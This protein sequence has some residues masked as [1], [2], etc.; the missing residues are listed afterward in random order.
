M[1]LDVLPVPTPPVSGS[2]TAGAAETVAL[3]KLFAIPQHR[4]DDTS[5]VYWPDSPDGSGRE[6]DDIPCCERPDID[7]FLDRMLELTGETRRRLGTPPGRHVPSR[8]KSDDDADPP[9]RIDLVLYT[10]AASAKS[11][12]ALRAVREVL[13]QYVSSQVK[14]STCDLSTSPQDAEA[15]SVVFTPTLVKQGPGP[16]TS[17][18]GNLDQEEILKDLLDASGVDRRRWDD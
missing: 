14:F 13:A 3:G 4:M 7:A 5:F 10:S 6:P 2:V 1:S 9:P 12:K 11:Q 18:I 15:D 16:R 8:H 17:I